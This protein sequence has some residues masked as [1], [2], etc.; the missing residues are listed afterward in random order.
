METD[1]SFGHWLEKQ[2]KALD[3][4]REE[5]AQKVGCSTSALR[6]IETDQRRPSR[7][8]AE[9]I[10]KRLEISPDERELFIQIARGD[11]SIERM[12][13]PHPPP[14]LNLVRPQ[15][16]FSSNIP[17]PPTP[18]IGRKTELASISQMLGDPQ[19][20][21][22]T[23]TGMGGIGK[24]RLAIE[25]AN[26]LKDGFKDGAGFVALAGLTSPDFLV[27]AIVDALKIT[28]AGSQ[29]VKKQLINALRGK[30]LLLVLDNAENILSDVG[31][32]TEMLESASSLKLLV[33]SRVQLNI[34]WE[35]VFELRGLPIP[36]SDEDEQLGQFDS[37]ALFV[38]R[39]QQ[40]KTN[41]KF[42]SKEMALIA[43][44]CQMVEGSPLA[45]ELAAPWVKVLSVQ[46]IGDEIE[47]HLDI[48]ESSAHDLP[49]RHRSIRTTFNY[50]WNLLSEDEKRTLSRL[51]TFR[52]SFT[53]EAAEHVTGTSLLLLSTLKT[54][55]WLQRDSDGRFH[56]HELVRQY[57]AEKLQADA[58]EELTTRVSFC[59]YYAA[60]L[61]KWEG[62]IKSPQSVEVLAEMGNEIDNIR[63][64]WEWM[65][66]YKQPANIS[67]SQF[68]LYWFH[69]MHGLYQQ[70]IVLFNHAAT[71]LRVLAKSHKD[72]EKKIECLVALG[73]VL[74]LEARWFARSGDLDASSEKLKESIDILPST[75]NKAAL[76]DALRLS[77]NI[78][79]IWGNYERAAELLEES[80]A[81][82][83]E[84]SHQWGLASSLIVLG[85]LLQF[86]G[87]YEQSFQ[88]ST[89][90]V[91]VSRVMGEPRML[92]SS[93][94]Y[95]ADVTQSLGLFNDAETLV[96][97]SLAISQS[98]QDRWSI[99]CA[100]QILGT[101]ATKKKEGENAVE[102]LRSSLQIFTEMGER[103][104]I[105]S[106]MIELGNA[107]LLQN[108]LQEAKF[109]FTETV[110]MA[111]E[112]QLLPAI[113]E[114]LI[115]VATINAQ[116]KEI[117][118]AYEL[119]FYVLNHPATYPLIKERADQLCSDLE[120]Q[121]TPGKLGEI[122]TFAQN[123]TIDEI[124][125]QV[126]KLS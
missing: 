81:L 90:A 125:N 38:Q 104:R 96:Q 16:T 83:R 24:T 89:E 117:D 8:L 53:R 35:W 72:Q 41:L 11:L 56:L 100:L 61:E 65:V 77:G 94:F 28:L 3:L 74:T 103:A 1:I 114:S 108:N 36:S 10:A 82:C 5:F 107:L 75:R 58:E 118:S 95:K 84:A 116:E 51:S 113:V 59:N 14:N 124:T 105:V 109:Y 37:V 20:R 34:Q 99:A 91:E 111:A 17:T 25:V 52:G 87:E 21:M 57:T 69:E 71:N 102:R 67:R 18:L 79:F 19:C 13:S 106:S 55:S 33:T 123:K 42:D 66:L 43:R 44:V 47:K 121:I 48:L 50:S 54:K 45:I 70:G 26:T 110:K 15:K 122:Q 126:L 97:E 86:Q 120:S 63:Q 7:Q 4:T 85:N 101:I 2:R 78:E 9:L 31:L 12:K 29:D 73:Q 98:I 40:V 62:R 39:A 88:V 80:V 64:A 46:E 92:A 60:Q 115:G 23:I 27:S 49:E 68:S 76:G 30:E 22:L 119:A 93:L 32:F 112:D 6:K